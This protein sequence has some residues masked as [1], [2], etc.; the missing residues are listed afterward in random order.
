MKIKRAKNKILKI[1]KVL[2]IENLIKDF[3]LKIKFKIINVS[4]GQKVSIRDFVKQIER[5]LKLKAKIKFYT[6]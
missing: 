3:K 1:N 6:N 2:N 5:N 4:C